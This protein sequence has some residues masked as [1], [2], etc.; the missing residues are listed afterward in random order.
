MLK[1]GVMGAKG[2]MGATV[3]EAV[4]AADDL[5]LV[6]GVDAGDAL[7]ALAAADVVVEFTVPDAAMDNIAWCL[8]HG[9]D[10][11]VGTTGFTDA[12]L[13]QVREHA[14]RAGRHV[15]VA[16]N[17]SIGSI[18]MMEFARQAAPYFESVEIIESHHPNKVD[19][20]S[21]TATTTARAIAQARREAGLGATPDA[22]ASD[23]DG[24]R[25]ASI[26]GI[27]VHAVRQRGLFANQEVRF[28]NEGEQLV[29]AENG[30]ARTAYMPGVLAAVRAVRTLPAFTFGIE[31]ILGIGG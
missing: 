31:G 21:G 11:V 20:P 2:R 14:E 26:D 25:G 28:G 18:L 30:F 1:V 4:D 19:A 7:D 24:A 16:S 13:D 8:D 12:R 3:C 9:L 23:P 6:A 27:H 29:I 17:F 22:T 10:V 5:E 15:L